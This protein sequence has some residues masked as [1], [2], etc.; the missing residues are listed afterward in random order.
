LSPIDSD[1]FAR[2]NPPRP[3]K[4]RELHSPALSVQ[5]FWRHIFFDFFALPSLRAE[6]AVVG[7]ILQAVRSGTEWQDNVITGPSG[8][9]IVVYSGCSSFHNLS[10]AML[11]WLTVSKLRN[12]NWQIRDVVI[13]CL[14]GITMIF[15]NVIRLCLMA[16]SLDLYEYWH[17][18]L[19]AQ[20]FAVGASVLVLLLSLYGS[21]PATRAS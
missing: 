19:G 16:S 9:G 15:C 10:L 5:E 2:G 3:S 20:I 6:T 21:R 8:F 11:C 12:Q 18:G 7:A 4:F 1:I 14:V 17:D 13:G